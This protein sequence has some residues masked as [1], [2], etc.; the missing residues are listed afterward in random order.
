VPHDPSVPKQPL[1]APSIEPRDA[2]VVEP[3]KRLSKVVPLPENREPAQPRLKPFEADLLEEPHVVVDRPPPLLIVIRDIVR[4]A[5]A[6]P[7]PLGPVLP[8]NE[9]LL[10]P[11]HAGDGITSL[12]EGDRSLGA[13]IDG[14]LRRFS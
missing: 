8:E 11:N 9:P 14:V 13:G 4:R 5:P 2:A 10:D 12:L 6:P 3:G 1:D 7:T